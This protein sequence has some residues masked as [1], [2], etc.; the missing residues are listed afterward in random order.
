MVYAF[1]GR[2]YIEEAM[3]YIVLLFIFLSQNIF[4][5]E[6]KGLFGLELGQKPV[7]SKEQYFIKE[8]NKAKTIKELQEIKASIYNDD[9]REFTPSIK[10]KDF[11]E[12]SLLLSPVNKVVLKISASGDGMGFVKRTNKECEERFE[13]YGNFFQN[14]YDEFYYSISTFKD[15]LNSEKYFI[16][17]N[18]FEK[19]KEVLSETKNLD[20]EILEQEIIKVE[21]NA[22]IFANKW[23]EITCNEREITISID[24]NDA[25]KHIII[26][27]RNW[28]INLVETKIEKL[29]AEK[30]DT[31]GM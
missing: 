11:S 10:N 17:F 8:V 30:T 13:F 16:R 18:K 20:S 1:K 28:V 27:E 15:A 26:E 6:I 22:D 19:G 3:K 23:I 7:P 29:T 31:S 4:A 2:G 24:S 9:I 12:Y 25:N 21:N 14:K 5:N